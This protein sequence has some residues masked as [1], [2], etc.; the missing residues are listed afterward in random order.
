MKILKSI[1]VV[2]ALVTCL[3]FA[4]KVDTGYKVGDVVTDF[5]LKNTDGKMVSMADFPNAKGF[6]VV[7]TCNMCPY[8][9]ANEDR[10]LALD[11]KFKGKG[12]PVIAINPNDPAVSPGDGF[13]EMKVRAAEKKFTFPYLF[14]EKQEVYPQFGAT[15]TPHVYILTKKEGTVVVSYIGAIDDSSRNPEAVTTRYVDEA[16][17][18]LLRGAAPKTTYTKAIGCSIKT[19]K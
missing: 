3:A 15:R 17:H 9:V 12:Y 14:D 10:I 19:K 16:V 5:S 18:A 1:G 11:R 4:V 7:F 8:S 6:I 2:V 13:A